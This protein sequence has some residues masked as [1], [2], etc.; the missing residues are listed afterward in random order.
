MNKVI[1]SLFVSTLLFSCDPNEESKVG[2]A[3]PLVIPPAPR[4]GNGNGANAGDTD[5]PIDGGMSVL[6][7]AGAAYGVRRFRN[8]GQTK[9]E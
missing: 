2:S 7:L 9:E 8:K 4:A 3:P 1:V 5:V 6:I